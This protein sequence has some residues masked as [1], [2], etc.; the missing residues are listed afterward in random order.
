MITESFNVH[1]SKFHYFISY[2]G[3]NLLIFCHCAPWNK[4]EI[5]DLALSLIKN[6]NLEAVELTKKSNFMEG[7][8]HN[9]RS[10]AARY[11]QEND[12]LKKLLEDQEIKNPK[13]ADGLTPFHVACKEGHLDI[14]E[15]L[16]RN[17]TKLKI[18]GEYF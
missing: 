2:F 1:L 17:F 13:N 15:R 9:E 16:V 10:N 18:T 5:L 7:L 11:V 8:V 6:L 14:A 4:V 3:Q 12:T